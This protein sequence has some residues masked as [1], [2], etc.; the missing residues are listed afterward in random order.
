MVCGAGTAYADDELPEARLHGVKKWRGTYVATARSNENTIP[1]KIPQAKFTY[2]ASLRIEFI[3]DEFEDEPA[4][5]RGRITQSTLDSSY[6]CVLTGNGAVVESRFSTSGPM[7]LDG[8]AR[9]ELRFSPRRGWSFGTTASAKRTMQVFKKTTL[10]QTGKVIREQDSAYAYA[11]E[12]T[13]RFP[14]PAKGFLLNGPNGKVETTLI[15]NSSLIGV[16]PHPTWEVSVHLEP[17]EMEELALEIEEPGNY[18]SWRPE[19]TRDQKP[20]GPMSVTARVTTKSGA[21]PSVRVQQFIWQLEDTSREPGVAMNYPLTAEWDDK[22]DI[23]LDADGEMF[24]LDE[25]KQR[26]ERAVREGYEDT[27]KVVPFDW[28]GWSKLQVTAIM[29]DGRQVR[30]KLKG[31]PEFGMRIPKR[32]ANSHIADVW[33]EKNKSGAD[34]LDDEKVAG[35]DAAGDGYTL[36]E[37]YRG[38]YVNGEQKS[39]DPK[40]KDFFVLNLMGGDADK[41]IGLF[42]VLSQLEVHVLKSDQE[43]K[44]MSVAKRLMNENR[45]EGAH[46]VDQHG[47]WIRSFDTAGELG[48]KGAR[49]VMEKEGTAGRPGLVKGIGLLKRGNT[50]SVFNQ[51][52]NL[53][54][55]SRP[56]V[57]DRAIAHELLHSVGV[58]HHGSGEGTM[59]VGYI[60]PRNPD[61]KLGRPYY[62]RD[63]KTPI[64]LKTEAGEDVAAREYP[65]YEKFRDW[66]IAQQGEK[67]LAEG[68]DFIAKRE[69]YESIKGMTPESYRDMMIEQILVYPFMRIEGVVG[70][71]NGESSGNQDCVMRY[72]FAKFYES[73]KGENAFY[74]VEP[75]SEPIGLTLCRSGQGTGINAA[76]RSPEPRYGDAA[77][78]C[79]NCFSQICPNDAVPPRN[80]P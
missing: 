67:Y 57:Y 8:D 50:E 21:K 44:E 35:Q 59:S 30:G 68:R 63:G 3:L 2:D 5:W 40:K 53:P 74:L 20:G 29:A 33:K 71:K 13:P 77:N 70:V 73:V 51:P 22:R 43:D 1:F 16:D 7:E 12:K 39:G 78:G 14:F 69:G 31:K 18:K 62:S 61:N 76:G 9:A 52:F 49:T 47:V 36:W 41:G 26:M 45:I 80:T 24:K 37:E 32:D 56:V 46:V 34:D 4:V 15:T 55:S 75:D 27:V 65:N 48:D 19:T 42:K 10:T 28:G 11:V 64:D 58:E 23:E 17:L 66:I 54:A 72:C 60:S 38:W 6:Y 25:H 79:G